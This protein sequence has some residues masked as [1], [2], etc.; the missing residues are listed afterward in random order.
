VPAA[1]PARSSGG[2]RGAATLPAVTE[3]SSPPSA[4]PPRGRALAYGVTWVAYAT[5]YFGRKGLGVAKATME[6][7]VGAHALHGVETA[8]LAAYAVG[9]SANGWFGDRVGARRLVGAG[10]LAS[11]AACVAFGASSGR[12]AFAVLMAANGLA[13]STGWPG[14]VKAM[15][16]WTPSTQRGRVM[17]LW[18]TCYQLGGIAASTVAGGFLAAYGWRWAFFG[19]AIFLAAVGLAVLLLLRPGPLAL[20]HTGAVDASRR[21]SPELSAARRRLIRSPTLWSYGAAYFWIKLIRYSLIYW[22]P[23]YLEKVHHYAPFLAAKASTSFE[24]GGV[25]GA[26][27]LGFLSD[28]LRRVPRAVVAAVALVG[29][30][31]AFTLY[32]EVAGAGVWPGFLAMA[33]CGFLLF[34]PDALLSGAAAQDA[35]GAEAAALAA[36]LVN[37][38]GSVGAIAEEVVTR[39]V[40]ARFGWDGLFHLFAGLAAVAA[41]C[42]WPAFVVYRHRR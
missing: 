2:A 7:A 28:H 9:Q 33:L 21:A 10:M 29:L 8:Y 16:E 11:A 22:L 12:L 31:G 14:N 25:A 17:G 26:V 1:R 6:G 36:G 34:G 37:A 41:I 15:A 30:A 24:I 27:S 23:Y 20:T 39:G 13:L 4:V 32:V 3:A 38:I 19:P 42:L 35:G 40:S 18:S 5:N